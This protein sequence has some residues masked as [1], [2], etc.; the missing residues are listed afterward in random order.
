MAVTGSETYTVNYTYD[1]N[2][3]LTA[4]QYIGGGQT[5]NSVYTYDANGKLLT[6]SEWRPQDG[7]AAIA[8]YSYNSFNQLHI[9]ISSAAIFFWQTA[10]ALGTAVTNF[11]LDGGNVVGEENGTDITTYLRGGSLISTTNGSTTQ[12]YLHNAHRDVVNLTDH[13]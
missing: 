10:K 4:S 1:A 3:R 13:V 12:Y 11:Y 5:K 7:I 8:S 6:K 2:N 9:S